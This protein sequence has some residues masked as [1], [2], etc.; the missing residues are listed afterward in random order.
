MAT[1]PIP[2]DLWSDARHRDGLEAE[3]IAAEWLVHRNWQVVASRYRMGRHDLD[4]VIRRGPRVVFVEV[5]WRHGV[6][7][8]AAEEA[9]GRRKRRVIEQVAWSWILRY[10]QSGD[11][12]RFDVVAM[13]G[14]LQRCRINH[15]EDAWRPGWK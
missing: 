4:L 12:Y 3:R 11:E 2:P 5:K 7:C 14:P 13:N 15:I 6:T 1:T 9:V 10:G 8:G